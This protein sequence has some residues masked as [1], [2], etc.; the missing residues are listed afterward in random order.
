[1][2]PTVEPPEVVHVRRGDA[3]EPGLRAALLVLATRSKASWGYDEPFMAAFAA[4]EAACLEQPGLLILVAEGDDQVA[5]FA[6]LDLAREPGWLEDLFVEPDWFG[7]GVGRR[8]W[9]AALAT[10]AD[11]GCAALA[12]ESDPNAEGFYLRLGA[13][14]TSL[15]TSTIDAGRQLPQMRIELSGAAAL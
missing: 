9:D 12:W 5:G 14:R 15:R 11:A 10:A 2:P 4:L 7:R 13:H 6:T 1:V 8:L 3:A